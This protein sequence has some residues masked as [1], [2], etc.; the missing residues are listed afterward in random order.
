MRLDA[1]DD[2]ATLV[3]E[4]PEVDNDLDQPKLSAERPDSRGTEEGLRAAS[5]EGEQESEQ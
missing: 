2:A 3:S 1:E 4:A 5:L